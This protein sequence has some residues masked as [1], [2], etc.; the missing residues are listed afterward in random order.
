MGLVAWIK[1]NDDDDDSIVHNRSSMS[2]P[3]MSSP[4]MSSP[5]MSSPAM[6][7]PVFY[8]SVNVQSC[9]FSQ[10]DMTRTRQICLLCRATYHSFNRFLQTRDVRFA[11]YEAQRSEP[12][13]KWSDGN[14][15]DTVMLN[16][17]RRPTAILSNILRSLHVFVLANLR[18]HILFKCQQ[19][20]PGKRSY[21]IKRL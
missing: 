21:N 16:S 4:S 8:S 17:C 14:W 3:A 6:S 11:M 9:N 7:N 1:W 5:S 2:S 13:Y 15:P 12:Q 19:H 10:P 18:C 20:K